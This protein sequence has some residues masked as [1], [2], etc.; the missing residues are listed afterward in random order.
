MDDL[1]N[2]NYHMKSHFEDRSFS[3]HNVN[4]FL[5]L[6]REG[7]EFTGGH[8]VGLLTFLFFSNIQVIC[9]TVVVAERKEQNYVRCEFVKQIHIHTQ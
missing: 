6:Q 5:P 4:N 2:T 3:Y 1:F 8:G 7:T 9:L